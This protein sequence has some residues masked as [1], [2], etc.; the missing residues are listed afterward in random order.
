MNLTLM[1]EQM[2]ARAGIDGLRQRLEHPE[3]KD[4]AAR[5]Q[6][7]IQRQ[8]RVIVRLEARL[9]ALG[10]RPYADAP[11]GETAPAAEYDALSSDGKGDA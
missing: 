10:A 7:K 9:R 1:A 6:R 3:H 4:H 11:L 8:A 2:A 5:L